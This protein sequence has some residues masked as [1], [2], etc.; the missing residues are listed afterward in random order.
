MLCRFSNIEVDWHA[1]E[2][3]RDGAQV[4]VKPK[5]FRLLEFLYEN[6]DRV[7]TKDELFEVVWQGQIVSDG[8]L[9]TAVNDLRRAL[10]D[11]G[12]QGSIVRTYYGQGLRF[13]ADV[14]DQDKASPPPSEHEVSQSRSATAPT[15]AH[16]DPNEKVNVGL[17]VL[18]FDNLSADPGLDQL[19]EI[20]AEDLIAALA[21]F[22][23]LAVISRTS[24]FA[25]NDKSKSLLE[26]AETLHA[27]YVIEGSLRPFGDVCRVTVQ[28]IDAADDHH[29]WAEQFE[30]KISGS[31]EEQSALLGK[32]T[33][34][35]VDQ[36]TRYEG[37]MARHAADEDL[38]AWQCYYRG[39]STVYT[40]KLTARAEAISY[41][42]RAI[43]LNP[44]FA[45][46]R[47]LLS[48]ALNM[49]GV[50]FG[51]DGLQTAVASASGDDLERAEKEALLSLELDPRY[52]YAWASLAR[53]YVSLGRPDDGIGAAR[54]AIKLNPY[55]P[56]A[57]FIMGECLWSNGQP[58]EAVEACDK[59]IELGPSSVFYWL[60]MSTK[61][62]ALSALQRQE[63]AIACSRD[64][65]AH[66]ASSVFSFFGEICA[67]GHLK[68]KE[69]AAT[70]IN[71]A[72]RA[73]IGFCAELFDCLYTISDQAIL[74][75][76]HEGFRLAG[77]K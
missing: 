2:V 11:T 1:M 19:G 51:A 46:A 38:T 58:E 52:A 6:R 22:S 65:Q 54:S 56:A 32:M 70:V 74:E 64:A 30:W 28:L 3:R 61:A 31:P 27:E 45:L 43:E 66:S 62:C 29:V 67:L 25:L 55:L 63:E 41:F 76:M 33:G 72:Q 7:V 42:Q 49:P 59:C 53:T 17:A 36:I 75:H 48:L 77:L 20:I 35:L 68:R 9:T 69:D 23:Q 5:A 26:I 18:A 8:A 60:A 44:E 14:E 40:H 34:Q 47:A 24:S 73:N 57:L 16:T 21:R 12:K 50:V 37:Q 15:A 39:V 10:A 71:R 13:V 4:T